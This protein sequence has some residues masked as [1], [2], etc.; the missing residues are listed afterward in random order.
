MIN[1]LA[2]S[3]LEVSS[4]AT[5]VLENRQILIANEAVERV[6]GWKPEEL[7]GQSARVLYPTQDIYEKV[8][9]EIYSSLENGHKVV[10][11]EFPCKHKN[12]SI[13]YCRMSAS[14]IGNNQKSK[15]V[16][17]TYEKI[18]G[19]KRAELKRLESETLYK[20]LAEKTFAGA[21]VVQD[22]KFR[23]LNNYATSTLGYHQNELIGRKAYSIVH[24]E[25]R[26]NV[27]K[28]A[29]EMLNG[30]RTAPYFYRSLNKKGNIQWI[31]ETVTS[32][33]YEGRP[34]VLGNNMD[35]TDLHEART[36]LEELN[37]L[38]SS[39]LD[40]TPNT[41]LY[42]ENRKIIFAN[43][44]V[45]SIF[46][47]KPEELIGK[48]TRILF[49]SNKDYRELGGMTYP[50]LE[51]SRIFN[52]SSYLYKHKDGREIICSVK[53]ARIGETLH[54]RRVIATHEDIT[55]QIRMQNALQQ[56]TQE[57]EIKTQN[58]EEANKALEETNTALH[59]IL[60]R[61]NADKATLEESV[62]NNVNILIMPCIQQMKKYH[63]DNAALKYM[64]Q[65]ESY[66]KELTSSFLNKL[67]HK[68]PTLTNREF[69]ILNYL[70]EGKSSKEIADL[71]NITAKGVEYHI[72][73]IRLMLGI[74]K[75]R[76]KLIPYL[77]MLDANENQLG[78]TH[79]FDPQN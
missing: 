33:T 27:R 25:D 21:Y 74:K 30:K 12:S 57:L 23:Y 14:R 8:G 41:I 32:I 59:V 6:F 52:K 4:L 53:I 79:Q 17:V 29:R 71:L 64:S 34:A 67:H 56:R 54:K 69:I 73:K 55:E 50:S 16:V 24:M 45:E 44:A 22:G 75:T 20:T 26:K 43:N 31:M 49:H 51:K 42:L 47:W 61:I 63:M 40:A 35:I 68:F 1:D 48:S 2:L 62:T 76:T 37:N 72:G 11:N 39:I 19:L 7:I 38:K 77:L 15:K 60:K 28:F 70:K 5:F 58:L 78:Y 65:A 66:L 9:E 3:I 46:G 18:G 36:K 13:I 10:N